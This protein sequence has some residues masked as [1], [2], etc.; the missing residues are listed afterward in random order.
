MRG[1]LLGFDRHMN[2]FL[3][4]VYVER[5]IKEVVMVSKREKLLK[6]KVGKFL[7]DFDKNRSTSVEAIFIRYPTPDQETAL[8]KH[9]Y[10]TF[11]V[12]DRVAGLMKHEQGV[13]EMLQRH[14]GY[15]LEL[16]RRLEAKALK[17]PIPGPKETAEWVRLPSA[18]H[19]GVF[20]YRNNVTQAK[21]WEAPVGVEFR[22]VVVEGVRLE[23]YDQIVLRGDVVIAVS[24]PDVKLGEKAVSMLS[25]ST[26]V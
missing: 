3:S 20:F 5:K 4:Q 14:A 21:V 9:L 26:G 17:K 10:L 8:W 19:P 6:L 24:N 11:K 16:I 7:G 1:K 25:N 15:E 12:L 2:I 18:K 22:Q 13:F 23:A